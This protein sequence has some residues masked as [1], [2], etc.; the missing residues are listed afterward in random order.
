MNSQV[1]I[2]IDMEA[3]R[4]YKSHWGEAL[5]MEYSTTGQISAAIPLFTVVIE[6]ATFCFFGTTRS[7]IVVSHSLFDPSLVTHTKSQ[8]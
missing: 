8:Q 2:E 5:M 4:V 3:K 7:P 1:I 6:L